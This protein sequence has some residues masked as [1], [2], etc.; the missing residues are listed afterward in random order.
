VEIDELAKKIDAAIEN[1]NLAELES[2]LKILKD[3]QIQTLIREELVSLYYFEANVHAAI[4]KIK[5]VNPNYPH[6]LEQPEYRKEILALR[7]AIFQPDFENIDRIRYCQIKTN[8]GNCLYAVGRIIEAIEQWN[9]VLKCAPRFGMALGNR[10][11]ALIFYADHLYDQNY[12]PFFYW[13]ACKNLEV[14]LSEKA[15]WDFPYPTEILSLFRKNLERVKNFG[16]KDYI[17]QECSL[18]NSKV[19]IDYRTWCLKERLFLNIC[20]DL[21]DWTGIAIDNLELPDHTY[22]LSDNFDPFYVRFYN[23]LKQEFVGARMLYFE[24][25]NMKKHFADKKVLLFD[26]SDSFLYGLKYEKLKLSFRAIYSIFDKIALFL[27]EYFNLRKEV[28]KITFRN[29]WHEEES[30]MLTNTKNWFLKG[31]WWISQDIFDADLQFEEVASPD[32]KTLANIRNFSEHRFLSIRGDINRH[33]KEGKFLLSIEETDFYNKTLKMMKLV[34]AALIY[35]PL[36]VYKEEE[37]SNSDYSKPKFPIQAPPLSQ[38][39]FS[40]NP[41]SLS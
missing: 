27:N 15:I 11:S 34:R 22:A 26:L 6:S 25:L 23:L 20:N 8:L 39:N 3:R 7:K 35:L 12:K 41:F 14:A 5:S 40:K 10:G 37:K 21:T 38:K 31:L 18:G 9:D 28:N 19:E 24:S 17:R 29:V 36:I 30:K 16:E 13:N 1:K 32:A 33:E 4:R 2:Y